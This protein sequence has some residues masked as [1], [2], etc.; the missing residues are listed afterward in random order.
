MH[1]LSILRY[2]SLHASYTLVRYSRGYFMMLLDLRATSAG[3]A[4]MAA[5]ASWLDDRWLAVDAFRRPW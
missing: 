2:I 3:F 5:T 4:T 1:K